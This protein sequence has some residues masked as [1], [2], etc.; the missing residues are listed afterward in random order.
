MSAV[1]QLQECSSADIEKVTMKVT[2]DFNAPHHTGLNRASASLAFLWK[3]VRG[4]GLSI[5]FCLVNFSGAAN[6]AAQTAATAPPS[7]RVEETAPPPVEEAALVIQNRTITV[8]RSRFQ[9]RSPRVRME[10]A[11]R[12]FQVATD[13]PQAGAVTARTIP[14]GVQVSIGEESIFVLTPEDLDQVS[15]ETLD[16]AGNRAVNNLRVAYAETLELRDARRISEAVGLTVL[17]T[18]LFLLSF[19]VLHRL[20][21][22]GQARLTRVAGRRVRD[23]GISGFTFLTRDRLLTLTRRL[24]KILIWAVQL[25]LIY[26]WLAYCLKRFPYT[27]PW[28]EAL[29]NYLLITFKILLLGTIGAL[30]GLLV[31]VI[32]LY[33]ARLLVRTVRAFFNAVEAGK[34]TVTGIY[35][36]TAPATRTILVI[37]IWLFALIVAYP[38]IRGSDAAVFKAVG[39]FPGVVISLSSSG[40]LVQTMSG[41]V[42]IYSRALKPGEYVHIMDFEMGDDRR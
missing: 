31:V 9:G 29:G 32:I 17:A 19:W 33:M 4:L 1:T 40:L 8:F 35:P 30:P 12:Q 34:V 36:D 24:L 2:Q 21:K 41:L 7:P 42:L 23:V 18:I 13:S 20:K 37:L 26:L 38:Y 10:G 6:L 5:L 28:G 3:S 15:E 22:F 11:Q 25:V 14:Q 39:V 16:E 27:R